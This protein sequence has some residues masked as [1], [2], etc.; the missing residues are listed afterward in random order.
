MKDENHPG[1]ERLER[2]LRQWGAEEAVRQ[3]QGAAQRLPP[4][5]PVPAA[6]WRWV[7]LAAGFA[8]F[9]VGVGFLLVAKAEVPKS[10]ALYM[11]QATQEVAD[12]KALLA[13]AQRLLDEQR[14]AAAVSAARADELQQALESGKTAAA[15]TNERI[16]DLAA[17]LAEK[18]TALD[19]AAAG[20]KDRDAQLAQLKTDL[21]AARGQ[22]VKLRTGLDAGSAAVRRAE[23]S[24]AAAQRNADNRIKAVEV[25]QAMMMNLLA[26]V[27]APGGTPGE[28][29]V[30]AIQAAARDSGLLGRAATLRDRISNDSVRRL[31]DTQEVLLMRLMLLDAG[32]KGELRALAEVVRSMNLGPQI[33]EVLR[34]SADNP[35]VGAW[36][37]E[38]QVLLMGIQRAG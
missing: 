12:A 29:D 6:A 20:L 10:G 33:A 11:A 25:Q 34:A 9:A 30:R 26:R 19:E 22:I 4:P 31:F 28:A 18:Q 38:S 14:T 27:M 13:E 2:L 21:A 36:L 5:L 7:P 3:E 24:A 8:L 1:R 35:E 32:D 15:K 17:R 23:E 37:I 16:A